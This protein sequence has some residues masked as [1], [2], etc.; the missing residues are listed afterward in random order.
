MQSNPAPSPH[1]CPRCGNPSLRAVTRHEF[2]CGCGFH[3]FHNAAAA[4][5]VALRWQDQLLVAVRAREPGKGLLDLPG[6]FVDPGESLEAALA[7][8]LAEELGL[9]VTGLAC[10]YLG[11]FANIYPYDGVVYHTCDTLFVI[12][13][14]ALP[15]LSP[16]DDVASCQWR[17][18]RELTP[19]EFAFASTR[20]ALA[21]LQTE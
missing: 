16:G 6:G 2:R 17:S 11:S 1:F 8:E 5:M 18:L 21:R 20:A 4:V 12:D 3:F 19:A 14:P 15:T 10:R 13:L 7:R 9:N